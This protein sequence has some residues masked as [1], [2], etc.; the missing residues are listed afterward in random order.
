M[1]RQPVVVFVEE[2]RTHIGL[3]RGQELADDDPICRDPTLAW[4]FED[5]PEP[6]SVTAVSVEDAMGTPGRRRPGRSR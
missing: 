4:V 3:H 1:H 5:S 6:G 2:T